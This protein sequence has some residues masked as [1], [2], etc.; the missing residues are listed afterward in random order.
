MKKFA[1]LLMLLSVLVFV[2]CSDVGTADGDGATDTT[3]S[4]E[5]APDPTP[6]DP[7]PELVDPKPVQIEEQQPESTDGN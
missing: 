2:G 1:S 3:P 7:Q 5:A 6:A 4:V